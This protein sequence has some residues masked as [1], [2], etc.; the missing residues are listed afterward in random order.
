MDTKVNDG[1]SFV[2]DYEI[3]VCVYCM[4]GEG[5]PLF[6]DDDDNFICI[7]KYPIFDEPSEDIN[8]KHEYNNYNDM[9]HWQTHPLHGQQHCLFFHEILD[10]VS[11]RLSLD[12]ALRIDEVWIDIKVYHQRYQRLPRLKG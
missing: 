2:N 4:L 5:D 11:P 8:Q 6:L 10:H 1:D 7:L 9:A 3:D 12:D